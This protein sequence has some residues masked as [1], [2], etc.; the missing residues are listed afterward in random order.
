MS[1]YTTVIIGGGAAGICAAIML[2]R[3]GRQ[4]VICEKTDRLGR[5][6]AA[7]GNG[8]CNL[9]NDRLG[10]EFY[11][12]EARVLTDAVFSRFD[13]DRILEFFHSL[14][15]ATWSQDGRVFPRTNQAAT[16]IK[17][18]ELELRR[19]AVPVRTGFDC[20][21][22]EGHSG[23]FQARSADG[24]TVRGDR[25]IIAGG[26]R[27]YPAFGAD[28]SAFSLAASLGHTI[29]EPAPSA[30][31]LTSRDPLCHALQG[32]RINITARAVIDGR[33][34]QPVAGELLFTKYGLSGTAVLDV[35]RELSI[36]IHRR[37]RSDVALEADLVPFLNTEEL[38]AELTRRRRLGLAPADLLTGLLPN[39]FGPVLAETVVGRP[40]D[41]ASALKARRFAVTGTR[42]WNE[43][44]FTAGGVRTDEVAPET[45]E[46]RRTQG[47]FLAGEVL[48]VDGQRGGYNLAWAWASGMAVALS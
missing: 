48:D 25:V 27:T 41:M 22:V 17:A 4:A 42:G 10:P 13:H 38:T 19:L 43:A 24:Q 1:Q 26:G 18:L 16:V 9:L 12:A 39:K 15:V 29:N 11:N 20:R 7:S 33:Y 35:S 28:G 40:A 3:A 6:L 14:G 21:S 34:G 46:S 2:A 47:V 23:D 31:P 30:V 45:L 32:Q 5:K 44:E 36:A 8:R 37:G